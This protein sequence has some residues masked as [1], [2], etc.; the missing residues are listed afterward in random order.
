MKKLNFIIFNKDLR[1]LNNHAL[2]YAS[3]ELIIPIFI[4]PN[5]IGKAAKAWLLIAIQNLNIKLSNNLQ[6]FYNIKNAFSFIKK[7]ENYS[8]FINR[9]YDDQ[10][11]EHLISPKLKYYPNL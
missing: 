7:H 11:K 5:N 2:F 1:L 8:I 9:T 3:K 4:F 6:I 10:E